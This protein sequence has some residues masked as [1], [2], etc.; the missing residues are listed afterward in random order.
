MILSQCGRF[1]VFGLHPAHEPPDL[2]GRQ[3]VDLGAQ[4][5]GEGLA[6][7]AAHRPCAG[8]DG[9]RRSARPW[10]VGLVPGEEQGGLARGRQPALLDAVVYR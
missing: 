6:Q 7:L 3:L 5:F 8:N 9:A 1:G 4:D 2:L 10:S